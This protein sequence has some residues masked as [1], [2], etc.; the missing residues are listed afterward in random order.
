MKNTIRL[1]S[2][3]LNALETKKAL[4]ESAIQLFAEQ[5]FNNVTVNQIV[6]R[7]GTAKGTFYT[8]FKSKN[9]VFLEQFKLFDEF[10]LNIYN[11]LEKHLTARDKL[12]HFVKKIYIHI[13][14]KGGVENMKIIYTD[15]FKYTQE[16]A[17]IMTDTSR[18]LYR[19]AREIINEGLQNGEFRGEFSE[20]ELTLMVIR[21]ITGTYFD[22]C[23]YDGKFDLV[24]NGSRYF[25]IFLDGLCESSFTN[26]DKI[27]N[28]GSKEMLF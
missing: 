26:D 8:Y 28:N 16:E 2:R 20:E 4:Y 5:G 11:G 17:A 21:C 23:L 15:G 25:S 18:P 3:Q 7:A 10:Y 1:T 12:Y 24:G 6:T 22:W 19:I 9:H 27:N 14:E 13:T